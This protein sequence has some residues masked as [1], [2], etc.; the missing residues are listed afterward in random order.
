[1]G[2]TLRS[3]I[4]IKLFKH[5]APAHRIK[6]NLLYFILPYPFLTSNFNPFVVCSIDDS[7]D[8]GPSGTSDEQGNVSTETAITAPTVVPQ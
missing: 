4:R 1:M 3:V 7:S 8:S 5:I 2:E 6:D